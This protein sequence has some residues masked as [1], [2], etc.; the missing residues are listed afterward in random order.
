MST[1]FA[2]HRSDTPAFDFR[3]RNERLRVAL[4]SLTCWGPGASALAEI[5]AVVSSNEINQRHGTGALLRRILPG[6]RNLLCI[7]A[8]NHWGGH[9]FGDWNIRLPQADRPGPASAAGLLRG[10]RVKQVFCVPYLIDDVLTAVSITEAGGAKLCAYLMDDQ[11]ILRDIIPDETMR[12]FLEKCS[13]RLATHPELRAA[14]ESKYGLAFSVLPAVVP[15]GLIGRGAAEPEHGDRRCALLGSFWEQRWFDRLCLALKGS[16]YDVDWFGN[17]RS[18]FV[19]FP[20]QDLARAGIHAMGIV[21]EERLPLGRY[22]LVLVPVGILDETDQNRGVASLSLP[23]R[24]LFTAATAHTPIL[25]VGSEKTCAARFVKHFGIG[26]TVPYEAAA[27]RSA[28]ERLAH[29][30]AQREMRRNAAA[31]APMLSDQGVGEWLETSIDLG[32]PLDARFEKI[33][34]GYPM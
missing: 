34:S 21:S 10:R 24:I 3:S 12:N 30:E 27:L 32:R 31:M 2:N 18:P 33:F 7:R 26:E 13:L 6:R 14:Y 28:M 11:N 22:P 29:P 16:G 19:R 9:D 20:E 8:R 5:D 17:N 25:V 4:D 23:G 15:H 1:A